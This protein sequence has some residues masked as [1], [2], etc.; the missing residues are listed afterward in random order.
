MIANRPTMTNRLPAR[1]AST[2]L[3]CAVAAAAALALGASPAA[4][5]TNLGTVGG[6]T[7]I[8]DQ[9]PPVTAPGYYGGTAACASGTRVVGGGAELSGSPAEQRLL[10]SEP[11]RPNAEGGNYWAAGIWNA[12]GSPKSIDVIAVCR[13]SKPAYRSNSAKVPVGRAR[14]VA[15]RCP[16]GTHVSAGGGYA[17]GTVDGSYVNSSFPFDGHDAGDAPDDGWKVRIY[18]VSNAP[19]AR[20]NVFAICVTERPRYVTAG[21]VAMVPGT[22]SVSLVSSA[23]ACPVSRHIST[24]GIRL[25]GAPA[26][27]VRPLAMMPFDLGDADSIPDDALLA[28]AVNDGSTAASAYMQAI[29]M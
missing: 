24:G 22:P 13:P 7:Y 25:A 8:F 19:R 11:T 27:Q 15:A 29:C 5:E 4:A 17:T 28:K 23:A 21:P 2:A 10:D 18:N 6:L 14:T 9:S 16:S 12:S 1:V 26:A 20:I 3:S